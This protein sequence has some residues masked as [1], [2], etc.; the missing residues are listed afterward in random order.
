MLGVVLLERMRYRDA[1]DI[2][3][4]AAERTDWAVPEVR[5]NLGLAIAKLLAREAND[6]QTE[7]VAGVP[8]MGA[9]A[10]RRGPATARW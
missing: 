9:I 7:L 5:H 1:L 8:G 4:D 10:Q 6:R 2:L 3:L